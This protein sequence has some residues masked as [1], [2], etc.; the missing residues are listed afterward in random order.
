MSPSR[1]RLFRILWLL[2]AAFV[3]F[4]EL[5]P[6]GSLP[7]RGFA[8]LR[9]P[10]KLQH[11]SG[12][13]LMAFFPAVGERER[14]ALLAAAGA[15]LLGVLLEF[16]QRLTETRSFEI[17]DMVANAFGVCAGLGLGL[18]LRSRLS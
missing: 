1:Q 10:D 16:A 11:F 14:T 17:A 13:T 18:V 6:G 9:I 5:L 3:T 4:G 12:Y 8:Y 2:T 7:M 15:V